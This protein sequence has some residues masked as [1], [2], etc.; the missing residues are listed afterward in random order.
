MK[1]GGRKVVAVYAEVGFKNPSHFSSAFKRQ[2]GVSP[3]ALR[4]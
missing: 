3:A 4:A 2:Y 1:E